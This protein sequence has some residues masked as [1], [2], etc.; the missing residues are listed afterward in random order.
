M[1]ANQLLVWNVSIV[2]TDVSLMEGD[3]QCTAQV[4]GSSKMAGCIDYLQAFVLLLQIFV[5]LFKQT[6]QN[7]NKQVGY[8][9]IS[10][11]ALHKHYNCVTKEISQY[12]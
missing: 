2:I 4:K 12:V 6:K 3:V 11:K 7:K 9:E 10:Q 8:L 5:F 1:L